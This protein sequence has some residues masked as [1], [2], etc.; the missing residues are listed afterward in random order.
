VVEVQSHRG[1]P[2]P[3]LLRVPT[4]C[5]CAEVNQ[6]FADKLRIQRIMSDDS[7]SHQEKQQQVLA[8][9]RGRVDVVDRSAS[10][11]NHRAAPSPPITLPGPAMQALIDLEVLP[12]DDTTNTTRHATPA[13]N[14][15]ARSDSV[16]NHEPGDTGILTHPEILIRAECTRARNSVGS[17]PTHQEWGRPSTTP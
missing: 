4:S 8:I 17:Q 14:T 7:L 13:I 2:G 12:L 16:P 10:F 5:L 11:T 15:F 1:I 9:W 3:I 6:A